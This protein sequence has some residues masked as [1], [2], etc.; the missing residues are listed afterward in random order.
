MKR[1][2]GVASS[3]SIGA[4]VWLIANSVVL[5]PPVRGQEEMPSKPL[6]VPHN[7]G[8]EN[9][10]PNVGQCVYYTSND[11]CNGGGCS[12]FST[13]GDSI[14]DSNQASDQPCTSDAFTADDQISMTHSACHTF[15][16]TCY[17]NAY[18]PVGQPTKGPGTQC[19]QGV[20]QSASNFIR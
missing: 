18:V 1:L 8:T 7:F 12:G 4:G 20:F 19:I 6:C 3:I 16:T 13:T 17:C 14:C 15:Y 2:Q 11:A 10:T 5:L 9:T